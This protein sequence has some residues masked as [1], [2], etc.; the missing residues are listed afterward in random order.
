MEIS[1]NLELF[2]CIIPIN[3]REHVKEYMS[4]GVSKKPPTS[5]YSTFIQAE[6]LTPIFLIYNTERFVS[7]LT[8]SICMQIYLDSLKNYK[9][10]PLPAAFLKRNVLLYFFIVTHSSDLYTLEENLETS[11][12]HRKTLESFIQKFDSS[13][14]PFMFEQ[15]IRVFVSDFK[16]ILD[17]AAMDP[18]N[19]HAFFMDI[20]FIYATIA[21]DIIRKR[22]LEM[23]MRNPIRYQIKSYLSPEIQKR[24][25]LVS[26]FPHSVEIF[27]R[28]LN[29]GF[30]KLR[31]CS[32]AICENAG[33]RMDTEEILYLFK[34][35]PSDV[36]VDY[37]T[38]EGGWPL[39]HFRDAI[40][41]QE[42]TN[43]FYT[44]G[45]TES[46]IS[47]M[48]YQLS[49]DE[50]FKQSI[51]FHMDNWEELWRNLRFPN[52]MRI[53]KRL[54]ALK[55]LKNFSF[56]VHFILKVMFPVA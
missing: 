18:E 30:P 16:R 34:F 19:Q 55:E 25:R 2:E 10:H 5:I 31:L 46:A 6:N 9:M 7:M 12:P 51:V 49:D 8:T 36:K 47:S 11:L 37:Y 39:M 29:A 53:Q 20:I 22:E 32:S 48:K 23:N 26:F 13:L 21:Q 50:I 56:P 44:V 54:Y 17:E 24:L 33:K 27:K 45:N 14:N 38:N 28:L 52:T 42:L 41:K 35:I 15:A 40:Y 4:T 3:I 1:N 43:T